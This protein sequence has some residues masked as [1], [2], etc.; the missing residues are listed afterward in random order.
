MGGCGFMC[1]H[2]RCIAGISS[3]QSCLIMIIDNHEGRRGGVLVLPVYSM[4]KS[5]ITDHVV[6]GF[7]V[8]M[9]T[10]PELLPYLDT[11]VT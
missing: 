2:V 4:I 8:R 11:V 6:Y 1:V 7:T 3:R 5:Y 9:V 10:V